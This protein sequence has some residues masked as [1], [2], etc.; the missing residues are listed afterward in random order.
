MKNVIMLLFVVLCLTTESMFARGYY[1]DSHEDVT[2]IGL[3][4][5]LDYGGLGGNVVVYPL[6]NVG[7]FLGV[8]YAMVGAGINVGMK[9]RMINN[10][11]FTKL[12]PYF[13]A[14]YG[15]NAAIVVTNADK[16]DKLFYGF[17]AGAGL[18]LKRRPDSKGYWSFAL[19]VPVRNSEV[20]NYIDDLRN[21]HGVAFEDEL[22]PLGFSVGYRIIIN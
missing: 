9:L 1:S 22:A 13:Q 18:D 10:K 14:M 5:G 19:L 20:G 15:Y 16:Y 11:K 6:K 4:A 8:G 21:N 7:L 17:S 2:S 12:T 3:G